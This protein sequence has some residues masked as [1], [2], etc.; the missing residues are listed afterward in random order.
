MLAH[1]NAQ[2][3][4]AE[5]AINKRREKNPGTDDETTEAL[6]AMLETMKLMKQFVK[7]GGVDPDEDVT[8]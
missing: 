2:I 1:M 7:R 6:A 5:Q 3:R 4:K 8:P